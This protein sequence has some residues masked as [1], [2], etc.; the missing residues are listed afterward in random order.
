MAKQPQK[1]PQ[2]Q[3]TT[4]PNGYSFEE[5]DALSKSLNVPSDQLRAMERRQVQQLIQAEARRASERRDQEAR[6]VSKRKADEAD[7]TAAADR[8]RRDAERPMVERIPGV[9]EAVSYGSTLLPFVLPFLTRR[10][11]AD[12]KQIRQW[13]KAVNEA[14]TAQTAAR[15]GTGSLADAK[16]AA[17][18]VAGYADAYGKMGKSSAAD[19]GKDVGTVA[20]T[21]LAATELP[22]LPAL[23]DSMVYN[24]G[25]RAYD[26]AKPKL[27]LGALGE[28]LQAAGPITAGLSAT[29]L[30]IGSMAN[31]LPPTARSSAVTGQS[32][33]GWAD[34]LEAYGAQYGRAVDA[35]GMLRR[36]IAEQMAEQAV[37]APLASMRAA[38]RLMDE[39][40]SLEQRLLPGASRAP[41]N[42]PP[43][44]ASPTPQGPPA[45]PASTGEALPVT[46]AGIGSDQTRM[47]RPGGGLDQSA[48]R[49]SAAGGPGYGGSSS[50]ASNPVDDAVVAPS[51]TGA[52]GLP[53]AAPKNSVRPSTG[54]PADVIEGPSGQIELPPAG[55]W[56]RDWSASARSAVDDHMLGGGTIAGRNG[57]TADDLRLMIADRLPSGMKVP[58]R[59]EVADRLKALRNHLGANPTEAARNALWRADVDGRYFAAPFIAGAAGAAGHA[60]PDDERRAL[61]EILAGRG[62]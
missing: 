42:S 55:P 32:A 19:W 51:S 16:V 13:E 6:A 40:A 59:S 54:H 57:L 20:G 41:G 58:S 47:I 37:A 27:T 10:Y 53:V 2:K 26:E 56:S 35:D 30:K 44:L 23:I 48:P 25:T 60:W 43:A 33:S 52:S 24:P 1:Q 7:A 38:G 9:Q 12:Q 36:K 18:R 61:A 62:Y 4:A 21:T 8:A 45:L 46:P 39:G 3:P 5:L 31:K 17:D 14:E 11:G 49:P 34:D 15:S 50:G 29:G 22:V 28:R